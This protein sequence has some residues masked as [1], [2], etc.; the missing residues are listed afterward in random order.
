[1][2]KHRL[3]TIVCLYSIMC[4]ILLYAI[5]SLLTTLSVG[6]ELNGIFYPSG[7]EVSLSSI[8]EDDN[9]LLCVT[10]GAC[11]TNPNRAGEFYYPNGDKVRIG[12]DGDD[13][14]RNRGTGMIR[15]NRRNGATSPT[16]TYTC[17]IPDS[18]GELQ[19]IFITLN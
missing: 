5:F 13:L 2:I 4:I 16:G 19:T 6:F 11:C 3:V 18:N 10:D 8:G 1:M 17:E 15:L 14:Y 7:S 9:A 12:G